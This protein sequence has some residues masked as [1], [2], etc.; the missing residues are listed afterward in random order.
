MVNAFCGFLIL[1]VLSIG[2]ASKPSRAIAAE[3]SRVEA[4]IRVYDEYVAGAERKFNQAPAAAQDIPWVKSKIAHMYEIDQFMRRYLDT[5]YQH[6]Y[7]EEEKSE[8]TRQFMTRFNE[9]D[10]KN[11]AE[12]KALLRIYPWFSISKFGVQTDGQAWLLVQHADLD[13]DFQ[14]MVLKRLAKLYRKGETKPMNYAYLFD[15]VATSPADA[16]QRKPQRYG[17]Q[18]QCTGPGTWVPFPIEDE[19]NVDKRRAEVGLG[20]EAEYI[21]G[22]KDIC[23]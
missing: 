3:Y 9:L 7:S 17:T 12:I 13:I 22:F 23:H 15:R 19:A 21:A 2:C 14:K 16:T 11:T 1:A 5:P 20:S 8:F 18:G 6:N 10:R 4:D